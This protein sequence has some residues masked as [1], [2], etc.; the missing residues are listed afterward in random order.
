[1][2]IPQRQSCQRPLAAQMET[3]AELTRLSAL[4]LRLS[5][6]LAAPQ[7]RRQPTTAGRPLTRLAAAKRMELL[8][9]R[10]TTET[11]SP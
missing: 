5:D 2:H 3:L 9:Q 11:Q 1:M 8:P 6:L 4:K 10:R 7:L